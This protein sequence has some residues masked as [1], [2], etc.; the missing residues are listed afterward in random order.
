M[1]TVL[2]TKQVAKESRRRGKKYYQQVLKIFNILASD[3][4][5]QKSE[6]LSGELNFIY[7]YHFNFAGGAHRLCYTIKESEKTIIVVMVGPRE[8]FYKIL[9]QKLS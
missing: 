3:P 4:I 6:R 9:K 7:S 8:N 2:A 1:Y 5:P